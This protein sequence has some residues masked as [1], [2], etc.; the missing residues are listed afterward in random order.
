MVIS[1]WWRQYSKLVGV[2][3]L[4][5]ILVVMYSDFSWGLPWR[6]NSPD[7][8]ANAFF[9]Q[10][11]A[12]GESLAAPAGLN[13]IT[14][15]PIV[16]PRSAHVVNSQLAPASFL[17]LPL[18]LGFVGRLAGEAVLPYLTPLGAI[19]GLLCF[20]GMVRE[21]SSRRA[22]WL[23]TGLLIFTPAFWYYHSRAFFHN[24]LFFDFLLLAV[25]LL[26]KAL[27]GK[28]VW[29][30]LG[31]GLA[32]GLALSLRTSEV[33]WITAA[34][35]LWLGLSW[36][37]VTWRYLPLFM[38]GA[39]LSFSPVLFTNYQIYGS[40]LSVGYKQDLL[41]TSDLKQAIGLLQQLVLPFGLHPR[42]ILTTVT[43]Y[44]V[45]LTW[46]WAVLAAAG[47]VYFLAAWRKQSSQAKVFASAVL[48]MCVWLVVVYGS[49]QFNDNP[50][51]SAV[52]LGTSYVRYWLP[53]Y[54]LLLWPAGV[55]LARVL[56]FKWGREITVAVVGGYIV[57]SG[58]LVWWE[59]QEGLWAVKEN[60]NRFQVWSQEVQA[61]T[62]PNSVIVSGITD[63]IFWP[64]REVVY[65][66]VN[67]VDYEAIHKLLV[68]NIPVYWFHPTWRPADITTM[69]TR[70][71]PYGLTVA[72]KQIGWQ[73]FSLYQFGFT[74]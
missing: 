31:S 22:A 50:D 8:A 52:T 44:L 6:F 66:L 27:K 61:V 33:F 63:K 35:A 5:A 17:G 7:E 65:A 23:A 20:Y 24:A 18:I 70:L 36:R 26:L 12:Q 45:E 10:R 37:Q 43:N 60:V 32:L 28:K 55:A 16:H 30:Y 67:P 48:V 72:T 40:I 4:A 11:L 74:P 51:P 46:W 38:L 41:L 14:Q 42:V 25:Y 53:L 73:D 13:D 57:L 3:V 39:L 56:D 2:V 19:L 1:A 34:G 15:N 69:N 58:L 49:W 62:E 59:P 54:G 71:S 64:E 47:I 29:L 9:A 68:N 21:L